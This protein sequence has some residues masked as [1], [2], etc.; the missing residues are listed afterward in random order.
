MVQFISSTCIIIQTAPLSISEGWSWF[1][2][3]FFFSLNI[4]QTGHLVR[5]EVIK[6]PSY[7]CWPVGKGDNLLSLS[8]CHRWVIVRGRYSVLTVAWCRR[9][10]KI[11]TFISSQT[12]SCVFVSLIFVI[13]ECF[14]VFGFCAF[15]WGRCFDFFSGKNF[16][17]FESVKLFSLGIAF[18]LLLEKVNNDVWVRGWNG[19][20]LRKKVQEN[21]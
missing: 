7:G 16:N 21:W 13:V 5:S 10:F 15:N 18:T 17:M 2:F 3:I 14:A 1:F 19:E 11:V 6:I 4:I 9:H 12:Q 8:Q 20:G